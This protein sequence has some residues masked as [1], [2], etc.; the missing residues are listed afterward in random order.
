M[1]SISAD[2]KLYARAIRSLGSERIAAGK[3]DHSRASREK[4]S[5][6]RVRL[7]AH[8]QVQIWFHLQLFGYRDLEPLTAP[9]H[10]VPAEIRSHRQLNCLDRENGREY[11]I[12]YAWTRGEQ[13]KQQRHNYDGCDASHGQKVTTVAR[14]DQPE[15]PVRPETAA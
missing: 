3:V 14:A 8:S 1:G 7:H 5:H 15:H 11:V 6:E 12:A 2:Q 10:V 13:S 4:R 9:G